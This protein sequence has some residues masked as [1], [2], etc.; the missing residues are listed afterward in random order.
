MHDIAILFISKII[1]KIHF[2]SFYSLLLF[3]SFISVCSH[4]YYKKQIFVVNIYYIFYL[5]NLMNLIRE[6]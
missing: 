6:N 3:L 2:A 4:N 1:L 5:W